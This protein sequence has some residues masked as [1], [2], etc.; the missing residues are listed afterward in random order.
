[1]HSYIYINTMAINYR[2]IKAKSNLANKDG[3]HE[4]F[5]AQPVQLSQ[6]TLQEIAQHIEDTSTH[7]AADVEAVVTLLAEKV[8][9]YLNQGSGVSL[10]DL[11]SIA[12]SLKSETTP[13]KKEFTFRNI[14]QVGMRY[15]PSQALKRKLA[16]AKF[17][18]LEAKD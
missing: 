18:D 12:I 6:V 10:G 8:A 17:H 13:T 2:V 11:G 14:K 3:K 7:S 4:S 9:Y 5:R 16:K 1:M 15:T